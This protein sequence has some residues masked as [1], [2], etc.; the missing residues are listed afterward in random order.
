MLANK[1]ASLGQTITVAECDA[2]L[3]N[4]ALVVGSSKLDA[5][6]ADRKYDLYFALF[7]KAGVTLSMLRN[8]CEAF[9]MAPS[10]GKPKWFPD[11]GALYEFIAEDA[12]TRKTSL[13]KL[14]RGLEL[15]D[16]TAHAD[17]DDDAPASPEH[18]AR[19]RAFC[20]KFS[21]RPE[22]PDAR[23]VAV[24]RESDAAAL[25]EALERRLGKTKPT[26][27]EGSKAA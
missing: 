17:P 9:A 23:P 25:R 22:R 2:C 14:R 8:A 20:A 7:K 5:D 21:V 27:N 4:L 11:P 16:G 26:T 3:S 12:R 13:A 24:Q 6:Q 18:L 15:I 19:M 1:I 10:N